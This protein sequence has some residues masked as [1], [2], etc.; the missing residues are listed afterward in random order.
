MYHSDPN[1]I[2]S[3]AWREIHVPPE[4]R[5]PMTVT[6]SSQNA[7]RA[8][9]RP[10]A[11][12][13]VQLAFKAFDEAIKAQRDLNAEVDD[14]F[15]RRARSPEGADGL[16]LLKKLADERKASIQTSPAAQVVEIGVQAVANREAEA[17]QRYEKLVEGYVQPGDSAQEQRNS[18]YA[19][20]I[21]R[22]LAAADSPGRKVAIATELLQ[23][24][25]PAQR[26]VLVEELPSL[27]AGSDTSWIERTLEVVDPELASATSEVRLASQ[28]N[29]MAQYAAA[30]V[31][32]GF[33]TGS[34]PV[35]LDVLR[36]AVRRLDP[37]AAAG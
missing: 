29:Q 1:Q 9:Q 15:K 35:A 30:K 14:D 24:A 18:R 19:Q 34:P 22:E 13:P 37:D 10:R 12:T 25:D 7:A 17:R 6:M 5:V 23:K 21:Q 4:E 20:Q 36:P 2:G 32:D 28:C 31:R 33:K 27:F 16:D 8:Q 26:G 3:D 11:E